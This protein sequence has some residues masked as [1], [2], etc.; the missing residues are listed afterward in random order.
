MTI[1]RPKTTA[2]I[3]TLQRDGKQMA[4]NSCKRTAKIPKMTTKYAK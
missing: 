3:Q 4:I 2:K 1:K